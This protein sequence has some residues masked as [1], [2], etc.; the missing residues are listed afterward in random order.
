MRYIY[1]YFQALNL[2]LLGISALKV[3]ILPLEDSIINAADI[4]FADKFYLQKSR[5]EKV[6]DFK[7][8]DYPNE[9]KDVLKQAQIAILN[10]SKPYEHY[11]LA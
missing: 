10:P 5:Y 3:R 11:I 4:T 8:L 2:V 1:L 7:T 6:L 9:I